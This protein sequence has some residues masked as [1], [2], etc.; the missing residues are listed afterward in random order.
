MNGRPLKSPL[1]PLRRP[2][3]WAVLCSLVLH[4]PLLVLLPRWQPDLPDEPDLWVQ[5]TA[6]PQPQQS[7]EAADP[8]ST[9]SPADT[10]GPAGMQTS[11]PM[12]DAA[13]TAILAD[14]PAPGHAGTGIGV[15]AVSAN[16]PGSD[17][18]R[19][20]IDSDI[21]DLVAPDI[22]H[23]Q[24]AQTGNAAPAD[25]QVNPQQ[26]DPLAVLR[27]ETP[28]ETAL[29]RSSEREEIDTEPPVM[30]MPEQDVR[31]LQSAMAALAGHLR[32][33]AAEGDAVGTVAA[34]ALGL[35]ATDMITVATAPPEDLS[36]LQRFEVSVTRMINGQAYQ[37]RAYLQ[38]RA[39]SHYAKF[40]NRWD[41]NVMLSN[42]IVDGRFH[43][44]SA[45]SFDSSPGSRPQFNGEVT[46]ASR[47]SVPSRLRNSGMFAG[48]LQTGTGRI[49]LPQ[50]ALSAQ[51]L[52]GE[53]AVLHIGRNSELTFQ[54][55]NGIVWTDLDEEVETVLTVPEAGLII[56]G[57][58]RAHITL[59][60]TVA[61]KVLVY[62]PRQILIN[63]SL[64]YADT[65]STSQDSLALISEGS[66]EIAP[67]SVTGAGDL[68]LHGALFARQRFAVRRFRDAHQG[69]LHIYGALI[70][71]S[72][73]A[74]EPRFNTRVEYDGR[75]ENSRPPAFPSTGLFDLMS[76][77][78]SWTAVSGADPFLADAADSAARQVP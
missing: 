69:T 76:W 77:E 37:M 58:D 34:E 28:A 39:L 50:Q 53:A 10:T 6:T 64:V 47:Q 19:N 1:T 38:E 40:I 12:H 59:S 67:A 54:G 8:Q 78:Q 57:T 55:D 60:G 52:D 24:P 71:G 65:S 9:D 48:G 16:A 18:D 70:A 41:D 61:G 25:R 45:V 5:L 21:S 22:L 66:I 73:S 63:G 51:W 13:A 4:L 23:T 68:V 20:A 26:P 17:P 15:A 31:Q 44:N 33:E 75:F 56:A 11:Q 3:L 2:L 14:E 29:V 46:I 49:S 42:D 7:P 72:V 30:V 35:P 62:S 43:A 36:A 27:G 32:D 74:T